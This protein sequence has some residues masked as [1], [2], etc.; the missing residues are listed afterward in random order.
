M[1]TDDR[2]KKLLAVKD[3]EKASPKPKKPK[4]SS[5][6]VVDLSKINDMSES[7]LVEIAHLMGIAAASRQLPRE[8]LVDLILGMR[9]TPLEDPIAGIRERTHR[10][11]QTNRV[12]VSQLPCDL[13]CPKC[14]VREVVACYAV[15]NDLFDNN[16]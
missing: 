14:P 8:E 10:Y 6:P 7:E 5:E 1:N 12:M 9:E 13:D 4:K 3:K 16:Q 2:L 11:V 15:N